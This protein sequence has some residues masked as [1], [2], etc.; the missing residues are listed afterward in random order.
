MATPATPRPLSVG[1]CMCSAVRLLERCGVTAFA[2]VCGPLRLMA[3][4]QPWSF[5]GVSNRS[6]EDLDEH[7]VNLQTQPT[8]AGA[9]PDPPGKDAQR[10]VKSK[11][12]KVK[13]IRCDPKGASAA[14]RV[15]GA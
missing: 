7:Q 15:R 2:R 1:P 8:G 4:G 5:V 12:P 10:K 9:V 6:A 3:H 14:R 11:G 13:L